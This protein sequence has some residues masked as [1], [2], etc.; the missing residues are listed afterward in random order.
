MASDRHAWRRELGERRPPRTTDATTRL[1]LL[2][3]AGGSNPKATRC[4]FS[5]AIVVDGTAYLVDC[6][7]GVHRQLHRAGLVASRRMGGANG[8]PVVESIVL[9][10]LHA[11]H[12][13]DLINVFQGSWPSSPIDVYGPGPAGPPFTT[14]DDPVHPLRFAEAPAP[15]IA[16]VI[17]HLNRAFAMNINARLIAEGR[18]DYIDQIEVHE[19]GPGCEID[20]GVDFE[21]AGAYWRVPEVEP[22][23][24]RPTDAHG[25][26]VT[27]TLA[28][29]AP[30]FPA[31]AFRFDTPAGSVVFSG[32]T[33]PCDNVVRLAQGADILVH[34]VIDLDG[35]LGKLHSL[36]N[37]EQ[38]RLQLARS[39]TPVGEVGAIAHRAGVRT[40]VLS[41]LVPGEGSHTPEQWEQLVRAGC[42]EFV[43]DVICGV[44]LDEIPIAAAGEKR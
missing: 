15:G 26:T 7:E 16:A 27:A 36:A 11:D 8:R 24:V 10:H 29:H 42:P 28:Q 43:G 32:D 6:G 44:D 20:P 37:F 4:G 3:T 40:L 17:D 35:L 23:L 33:G 39:H 2:G 34:E 5:N 1:V 22:F 14:H 38:V 12:V 18:S 25:V 13:M 41:H 30:V 9:T 21:R 19:I 31:L